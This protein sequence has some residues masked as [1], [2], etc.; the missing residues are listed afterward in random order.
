[1]EVIPAAEIIAGSNEIENR[2]TWVFTLPYKIKQAP[3]PFKKILELCPF[4]CSV[5]KKLKMSKFAK[6]I[7]TKSIEICTRPQ[8]SKHRTRKIQRCQKKLSLC[9]SPSRG[10]SDTRNVASIC[11]VS[12]NLCSFLFQRAGENEGLHEKKNKHYF[13]KPTLCGKARYF[14]L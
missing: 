7:K 14:G 6:F 10:A 8:I 13:H 11:N 3:S 9:I 4:L 12:W 5:E 1:M 2:K